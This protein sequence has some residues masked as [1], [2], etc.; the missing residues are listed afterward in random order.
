M[1][2][3]A[4]SISICRLFDLSMPSNHD[5]TICNAYDLLPYPVR[6]PF[7]VHRCEMGN[8]GLH[9]TNFFLRR[10][11]CRL[12]FF[13]THIKWNTQNLWCIQMRSVSKQQ[14]QFSAC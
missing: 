11:F 3:R 6:P 9:S 14:Q 8:G 7:S 5:L 2:A 10:C 13:N 12:Y 4:N 1:Y